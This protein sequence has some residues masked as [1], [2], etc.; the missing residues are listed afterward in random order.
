MVKSFEVTDLPGQYIAAAGVAVGPLCGCHGCSSQQA[1]WRQLPCQC[2][3]Q[4]PSGSEGGNPPRSDSSPAAAHLFLSMLPAV[5]VLQ[6]A[7]PSSLRA[8]SGWCVAQTTCS[9]V[10][11]T[12]TPW[13]RSRPSRHTQTTSGVA[14]NRCHPAAHAAAGTSG[15]VHLC[16]SSCTALCGW[17]T[18][19]HRAPCHDK[20]LQPALTALAP[21]QDVA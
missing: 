19:R 4:H 5:C 17:P 13:T 10:C 1:P 14:Y 16:S 7:L 8:S 21:A 6:S 2:L 15:T 18:C 11:T 12:T 3:Y 9:C 20:Q